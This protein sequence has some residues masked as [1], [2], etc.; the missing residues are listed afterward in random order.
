MPQLLG[1]REAA[2]GIG[3]YPE[4]RSAEEFWRQVAA[5]GPRR[6]EEP[7]G[8]CLLADTLRA[9]GRTVHTVDRLPGAPDDVFRALTSMFCAGPTTDVILRGP[10]T[11]R[12]VAAASAEQA[13]TILRSDEGDAFVIGVG[14]S[15]PL[16]LGFV[17]EGRG[18]LDGGISRRPGIVTP[19]DLTATIVNRTGAFPPRTALAGDVLEIRAESDPER[20]IFAL[21]DRLVRDAG[22]G[23]GIS[24]ATVPILLGGGIVLAF[25]FYLLG[26]PGLALRATRGGAVAVGGYVATLFV[27]TGNAAV[28]AIPLVAAYVAGFAWPAGNA[29]RTRREIGVIL[30]ATS[31]GIAALTLAAAGRPGAEPALGLWGNPLESWRFFGLR[32]HLAAMFQL[33]AIAAVA[34][35]SREP[36]AVRA[37]GAGVLGAV[38]LG[39]PVLAANFVAVLTVLLGAGIVV[40]VVRRR[41]VALRDLAV[42]GAASVA[43]F[44]LALLSDA[45]RQISHGGRAVER[46]RESGVGSAW[47]TL[48]DRWDINLDHIRGVWGGPAWAVGLAGALVAMFLWAVRDPRLPVGARGV[49]AGGAAASLAALVLEDTGFFAGGIIALAPGLVAV[50]VL[51]ERVRP[52]RSPVPDADER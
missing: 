16:F 9:S 7:A 27:P 42:A 41:R 46:I 48:A 40:A 52:L 5:G 2:W 3:V 10:T 4:S 13:A 25:L 20:A 17:G 33:G 45:G 21:A 31:V 36:S 38:V 18:L 44:A 51:A 43:G 1:E 32:N 37:A 49:M 30:G 22:I 24:A 35:A 39:A 19:Y 26:A 23:H 14:P 47:S 12:A 8:P 15:T 34:L 11:G 28:R 6:G 50:G 29:V